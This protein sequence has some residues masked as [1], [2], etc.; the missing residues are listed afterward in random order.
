MGKRAVITGGLGFIGLNLIKRLRSRGYTIKVLDNLSNNYFDFGRYV[1]E[2]EIFKIDLACKD[3]VGRAM[4]DTDIVF[5]LAANSD[6]SKS[7]KSTFIDVQETI[8]NTYNVLEGMRENGIQT[9]CYTSGSGVYGNLG[10]YAAHECY[11]PL[12]PVSLYGATKLSAEAIIS[13][14]SDLFGIKACIFRFANVVGPFQ[15]HGVSIDFVNRL[16]DNSAKLDVLGDGFQS[17]S[18]VHVEDVVDAIL[19]VLERPGRLEVFNVSSGDYISVREIA[20][21]IIDRMKLKNTQIL[22]QESKIGWPGDVPVIRFDDSKIRALGWK[23]RFTS[24]AAILDSVDFQL[25]NYVK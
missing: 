22:Y 3:D 17:K 13:S 9:I 2:N 18:Y 8:L 24:K 10:E 12:Q 14:F 5:H 1:R 15:T 21:L 11:G 23:N 25:N 16:R 20:E 4:A 7:A 19:M 6:I